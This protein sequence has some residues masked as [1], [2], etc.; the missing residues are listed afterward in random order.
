MER[1]DEVLRDIQGQ[2]FPSWRSRRALGRRAQSGAAL[3]A[4]GLR[5][6]ADISR[7][8]GKAVVWD[9]MLVVGGVD[10]R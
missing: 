1:E 2:A 9:G 5:P 8:D 3:A 6:K 10:V 7:A 4:C